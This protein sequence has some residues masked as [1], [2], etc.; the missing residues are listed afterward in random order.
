MTC[1]DIG[2]E[3]D[4]CENC[5]IAAKCLSESVADAERDFASERCLIENNINALESYI[6]SMNCAIEKAANGSKVENVYFLE[7]LEKMCNRLG[8]DMIEK[9]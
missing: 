5:G 6:A 3:K 7:K 2:C 9:G 8:Y 4:D 1:K